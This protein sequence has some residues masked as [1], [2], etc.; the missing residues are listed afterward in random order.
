MKKRLEAKNGADSS[1]Q[2]KGDSL[3]GP[4]PDSALVKPNEETSNLG[5]D[6]IGKRKIRTRPGTSG[7]RRA[8]PRTKKPREKSRKIKANNS[9]WNFDDNSRTAIDS[10]L[11]SKKSALT[12]PKSNITKDPKLAFL[13]SDDSDGW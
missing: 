8:R 11:S 10:N 2:Q 1:T 6:E 13:D 9:G 4:L 5:Y 7:Q 3:P 12:A